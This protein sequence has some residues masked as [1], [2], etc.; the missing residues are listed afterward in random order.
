MA[1]RE[2]DVKIDIRYCSVCHSDIHTADND[3]KNA[4]YPVI[5]GHEIVGTVT[6]IGAKVSQFKIGDIVGVGCMIDSC[7]TCKACT[8]G[9]EQHCCK[10]ATMTMAAPIKF[11][12][13]QVTV[14]SR[15]PGKEE[16]AKALRARERVMAADV[17]YLFVIDMQSLKD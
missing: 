16:D 5:P 15:S 8:D 3:W 4:I 1:P 14:L 2:N 12:G 10:R 9:D 7:L 6:E 13:A 11:L 17:R